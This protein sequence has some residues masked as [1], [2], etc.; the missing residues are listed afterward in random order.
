MTSRPPRVKDVDALFNEVRITVSFDAFIPTERTGHLITVE[1]AAS[2]ARD[3]LD[4]PLEELLAREEDGYLVEVS[5]THT[6][7]KSRP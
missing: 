1:A 6:Q 3:T 5:I 4:D 7:R 2:L